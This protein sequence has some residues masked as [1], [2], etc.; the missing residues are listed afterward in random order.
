MTDWTIREIDFPADYDAC[1]E[2]WKSV[3][4]GVKFGPSDTFEEIQK[5]VGYAPDLFLVAESGGQIIATI[6]G[7][8]D[9]RRGMIY[10]LAVDEHWRGQGLAGQ[11]MAGMEKRLVARGCRKMYLMINPEHPELVDFYARMGWKPMDV[12]IAAKEINYK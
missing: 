3:G 9:G 5:K 7:G 10:H 8:F 4:G 2:L 11:L 6:I 12:I 1:A